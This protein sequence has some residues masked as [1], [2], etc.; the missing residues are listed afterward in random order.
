MYVLPNS[1]IRLDVADHLS[2]PDVYLVSQLAPRTQFLAV[3]VVAV[4]RYASNLELTTFL[5]TICDDT[6]PQVVVLRGLTTNPFALQGDDTP[7]DIAKIRPNPVTLIVLFRG[8]DSTGTDDVAS[9]GRDLQLRIPG[10]TVHPY[11]RLVRVAEFESDAILV[12]DVI[13]YPI[14]RSEQPQVTA[15]S[16]WAVIDTLAMQRGLHL[17]PWGLENTLWLV[18]RELIAQNVQCPTLVWRIEDEIPQCNQTVL[19]RKQVSFGMDYSIRQSYAC[20]I[21]PS[22]RAVIE[23]V[24]DHGIEVEEDKA[25]W[26]MILQAQ[27]YGLE[28]GDLI[29]AEIVRAELIEFEASGTL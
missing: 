15:E 27:T 25:R 11:A 6:C 18:W 22:F 2:P 9:K 13:V 4:P 24:I 20:M 7:A 1:C 19:L 8:N 3:A 21:D 14:N 12:H 26:E 29:T 16:L 17:G 28:E 23:G 5:E 10:S